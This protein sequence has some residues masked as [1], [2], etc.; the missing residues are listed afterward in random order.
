MKNFTILR[1]SRFHDLGHAG[2]VTLPLMMLMA[3]AAFGA[4]QWTCEAISVAQPYPVAANLLYNVLPYAYTNNGNTAT[5][6]AKV[7]TDG[8]I[9]IGGAANSVSIYPNAVVC[10]KLSEEGLKL[11]TVRVTSAW[12]DYGRCQLRI[13]SLAV[14]TV[15]GGDEWVEFA[16]SSITSGT[17]S[18]N[19]LATFE[20]ADG[21]LAEGVTDLRVLFA[22]SQQ[23]GYAGVTEIEACEEGADFR[24][25]LAVNDSWLTGFG[26]VFI[27]P[28]SDVLKYDEGTGVTLTATGNSDSPF[29]RWFGDV[30]SGHEYD[31]P[32]TIVM[33]NEKTVT[34]VFSRPWVCTDNVISD[35]YWK[36]T[37]TVTDGKAAITKVE[38]VNEGCPIFDMRKAIS[39]MD[40]TL[41]SVNG[42]V[43]NGKTAIGELYFPDTISALG[44]DC[45]RDMTSLTICHLPTNLHSL[46]NAA[47]YSCSKLKDIEP[48]LP[49]GISFPSGTSA[50]FGGCP[51]KGK[52]TIAGDEVT[53]LGDFCNGAS[54]LKEIDI[55]RTK[56]E[57]LSG[58]FRQCSSVTNI[59]L[60][61]TLKVVNE[62]TFRECS[63]LKELHFPA[64]LTTVGKDMIYNCSSM[65]QIVF[66]SLPTAWPVKVFEGVP[67][68]MRV[69][70]PETL[71]AWED[72]LNGRNEAMQPTSFTPVG[73]LT[74]AQKTTYAN[75][76]PERDHT[77]LYGRVKIESNSSEINVAWRRDHG[78]VLFIR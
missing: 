36:V 68:T 18:K 16:N 58:T 23:N 11:K 2:R 39:G 75:N 10:Y 3:G 12:Q 76:F 22:S 20:D 38:A 34:P 28:E 65:R 59:S 53:A 8:T 30:P 78:G 29:Y 73:A 50:V 70:Y 42:N 61:K 41:A 67:T 64:G 71:T 74:S 35:G 5:S 63:K 13:A 66:E 47:F 14:K 40:F 51:L 49:E 48:L 25:Q 55:S 15:S 62:E 52:L 6:S 26:W 33:D 57:T 43:F 45:C 46:G 37:T 21:N 69:V 17:S 31:N 54:G 7:L 44:S 9:Q 77:H 1:I 32:L 60:P 56:I 27:S 4:P 24:R 19:Y 72:Y